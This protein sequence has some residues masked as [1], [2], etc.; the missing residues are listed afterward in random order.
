MTMPEQNEPQQFNEPEHLE[1]EGYLNRALRRLAEGLGLYLTNETGNSWW[2]EENHDLTPILREM[3]RHWRKLS[4]R[5][6][7][8]SLVKGLGDFRNEAYHQGEY[9]D[10]D[11]VVRL[12]AMGKLLRAVSA[13]EQAQAVE[14]MTS[15][16]F[17]LLASQSVPETPREPDSEWSNENAAA[18]QLA[19]PRGSMEP[20][21]SSTSDNV[22]LLI[23]AAENLI[24]FGI[25]QQAIETCSDAIAIEPACAE[26]YFWRWRARNL[27]GEHGDLTPDLMEA[28]RDPGLVSKFSQRAR[29]AMSQGLL[30]AA[31]G[32]YSIVIDVFHR[33]LPMDYI[34]RGNANRNNGLYAQAFDDYRAA[35]DC[36]PVDE[37][38][39]HFRCDWQVGDRLFTYEDHILGR[40]SLVY[41]ERGVTNLLA[42]NYETA[43]SDFEIV[44][45]QAPDDVLTASAEAGKELASL[46]LRHLTEYDRHIEENPDDPQVWHLRGVHYLYDREDYGLAVSDFSEAIRLDADNAE[47]WKD[48]GWAHYQQGENDLAYDDYSRAIEIKPDLAE[49]WYY[50]AWVWRRRGDPRRAIEDFDQAIAIRP[51]YA[52]AYQHRGISYSDLV[53]LE[54]AQADFKM[55]WSLGFR[56]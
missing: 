35:L 22:V 17:K 21:T 5:G 45:D 38:A 15:E 37:N 54:Q 14:Q 33:R 28:L 30:D 56:P 7:D 13:D 31:I 55:A 6:I 41:F 10:N 29:Y 46:L 44:V 50:R 34:M 26:A 12:I 40:D 51:D 4:F 47:V 52:A 53:R 20:P 1:T 25:Y 49:A 3:N 18:H 19:Q 8:E 39:F 27:Q 16:L 9:S 32:D 11:V 24:R 48:L 42:E 43:V 36:L 23:N 2:S